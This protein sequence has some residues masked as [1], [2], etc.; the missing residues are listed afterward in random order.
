MT[1]AMQAHLSQRC[2]HARPVGR[3]ANKAS[4][5][6]PL[7]P[8]FAAKTSRTALLD[9]PPGECS[10]AQTGMQS[11]VNFFPL[12]IVMTVPFSADDPRITDAEALAGSRHDPS[13][14]LDLSAFRCAVCGKI[15]KQSEFD[16]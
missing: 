13:P 9:V 2:R 14:M 8:P 11:Q 16:L 4:G 12:R 7:D 15:G 6:F 10:A 5:L 1:G 3:S